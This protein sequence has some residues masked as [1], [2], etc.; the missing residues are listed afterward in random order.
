MYSTLS[1]PL[2]SLPSGI[3]WTA[4]GK[5]WTLYVISQKPAGRKVKRAAPENAYTKMLLA[6]ERLGVSVRTLQRRIKRYG[7]EGYPDYP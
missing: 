3:G 2:G 7:L 1:T 6:A 4:P 5:G